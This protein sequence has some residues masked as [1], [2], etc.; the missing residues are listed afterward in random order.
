MA[1][2]V[3]NKMVGSAAAD[4][5]VGTEK[6]DAIDGGAG[7]DRLLGGAGNDVFL[8]GRG[9]GQDVIGLDPTG[10]SV[11]TNTLQFKAGILSSAIV[12]KRVG[13]NRRS[14]EVSIAGTNDKVTI[15]GF[16]NADDTV[17]KKSGIQQIKFDNGAIWGVQAILNRLNTGTAGDDVLMGSLRADN[18][19]GGAGNDRLL[20][21]AGN[22]TLDGGK[23]N[24]VFVGGTGNDTYLFGVGDGQDVVAMDSA[25]EVGKVNTLQFKAGIRSVDVRVGRSANDPTSLELVL[26]G[27]DKVT[28]E[29]FFNSDDTV[30]ANAGLQLV[31]FADNTVWN[32]QAILNALN[33]GT[34]GDDVIWG[35][36]Q[37]DTMSGLA[38]NDRLIGGPGDD[39]LDGGAGNDILDGWVGNDTYLFGVGDGQ[40]TIAR[41]SYWGSGPRGWNTLQFKAGI[42]S[43]DVRVGRAESNR[44][45]LEVRL[46]GTN[47]KVTIE[48]FFNADD[49]VSADAGIEQIKFA[50]N[51]V[52]N[53]QAILNALN[54]GTVGDDVIWGTLQSDTMSGL[55]G[56]DRLMGGLGDDVLDG[57][58]GNDILDGWVG[59]DTYLFGVGDGQDT[60]VLESNGALGPK[61]VNTLQ[62]KAGIRSVDVRVGRAEGNRSALEVRL[63]GT[64]DK[65]TIEGF[66]NADDSVSAD[67]GIEQIKF[68][69][70]TVWNTQAILNALNTG[71]AGDD[72]IWGTLQSDTMSGLAGNDMLLGDAGNDTLD[73]G[74]G[75][76]RLVGEGGSDTYLFGRG[77]GVDVIAAKDDPVGSVDVLLFGTG[78]SADQLWFTR[79][80]HELRVSILGSQDAVIVQEW[81]VGSQYQVEQFKTFDGKT[82]LSSQVDALVSAMAAFSP[83]TPGQSTLPPNYQDALA[84]VL[85]AS[86]K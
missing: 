53:T 79:V 8:F 86:W 50:D 59:N 84:V 34:A 62:F 16:F 44:S 74:A 10:V 52:W 15:E 76:D 61:G 21:G 22:D 60:I 85:T 66:F 35:T 20:G 71:T 1:N 11:G 42:R 49:S 23:G 2:V 58:A 41:E 81:Y 6:A 55:A 31:K 39:I 4:V 32:T 51:T 46:L 7:N 29:K 12:I 82:L 57:G 17:N 13:E 77:S 80:G 5:L 72:V 27:T 67:A 56:N 45:A 24:D 25:P 54:T 48:G 33:T 68:A 70:N 64:N 43:V 78:V 18:M 47:D 28:I 73:G 14:L 83:P 26:L 75:N 63:L 38:G 36:L 9:D 65:V 3:L 40:D 30:N 69:D 37:S 19:I